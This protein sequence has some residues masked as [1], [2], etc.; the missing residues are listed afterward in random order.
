[1]VNVLFKRLDRD[2]L[3]QN[4]TTEGGSEWVLSL[5]EIYYKRLLR[6][7]SFQTRTSILRK[8]PQ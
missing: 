7:C 3:T 2:D 5:V 6:F 8:E 1:M 4:L